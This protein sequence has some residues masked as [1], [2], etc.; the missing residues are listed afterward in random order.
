MTGIRIIGGSLKGR[1][2]KSFKND[3]SIRPILGRIKKSLFDILRNKLA[4]SV[5]LDLYAGTG[6]VGI[7]ALSRGAKSVVFVDSDKR[8]IRLINENI[9]KLGLTDLSYVCQRDVLSGLGWLKEKFDI[10]FMGPPYKDD[11]KEPLCLT[12]VTLGLISEAK[13]LKEDGWIIAQHHNKEKLAVPENL[14]IFRTEKYGD[15]LVDFLSYKKVT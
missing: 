10:I 15:T 14:S 12:G 7:E 1:S 6:A 5:F 13:I 11:K 8:C 2:V 4:G 3:F 9:N